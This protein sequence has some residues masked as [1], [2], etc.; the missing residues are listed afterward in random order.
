MARLNYAFNTA[1]IEITRTTG[2]G[3]APLDR[4]SLGGPT[5]LAFLFLPGP[6]TGPGRPDY[7]PGPA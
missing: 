4:P 7:R 3:P 1:G 5:G 6:I 2:P